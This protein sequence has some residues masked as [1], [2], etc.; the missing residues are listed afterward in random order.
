MIGN[1][2]TPGLECGMKIFLV[3]D[4]SQVQQH[5]KSVEDAAIELRD[6]EYYASLIKSIMLTVIIV[7]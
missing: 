2:G 7:W 5:V 4:F 1:F 6:F 3:E